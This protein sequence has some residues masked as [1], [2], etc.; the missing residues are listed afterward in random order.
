M[1]TLCYVN[2]ALR[3]E[4]GIPQ[5]G[6]ALCRWQGMAYLVTEMADAGEHHGNAMLIGCGNDFFIAN[7]A[8]RLDNAG[9]TGFSQHIHA[10]AEREERIGGD[11]RTL[12]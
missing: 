2:N 12:Q 8:T 11:G 7:A 9:G 4:T 10:I 5:D 3:S 1:L 6:K